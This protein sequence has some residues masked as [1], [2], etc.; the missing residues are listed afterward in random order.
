MRSIQGTLGHM[1]IFT[2]IGQPSMLFYVHRAV[3]VRWQTLYD[4]SH[5]KNDAHRICKTCI[6]IQTSFFGARL[7][8]AFFSRRG[9][10]RQVRQ[11]LWQLLERLE[12]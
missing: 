7:S 2:A 9:L 5:L 12:A 10:R 3:M 11:G 8:G 1:C 4:T 6:V